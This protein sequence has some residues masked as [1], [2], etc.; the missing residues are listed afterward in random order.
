MS[1][2]TDLEILKYLGL[3]FVQNLADYMDYIKEDY[4][5]MQEKTN[6]DIDTERM[7]IYQEM[8]NQFKIELEI[9][10]TYIKVV[11]NHCGQ[12]STHS[13]IVIRP[14]KFNVGDVLKANSWKAPATNFVRCKLLDKNTWKGRVLWT[15]TY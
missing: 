13:F 7:R 9:G 8:Y 2:E 5:S 14:G 1:R 3:N 10:S 15:G 11:K 12:C 4:K 6:N